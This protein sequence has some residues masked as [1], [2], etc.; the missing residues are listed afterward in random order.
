MNKHIFWIGVMVAGLAVGCGANESGPESVSPAAQADT[1]VSQAIG[2]PP[3]AAV[4]PNAGPFDARAALSAE[5]ARALVGE[6]DVQID[7][8]PDG[9]LRVAS[10][11]VTAE[12]D[13]RAGRW[14]V[15]RSDEAVRADP[16][17]PS[18][19]DAALEARSRDHVRALGIADTEIGR[20]IQT[21]VLAE[22]AAEGQAPGAPSVQAYKTFIDRAVAGIPVQGSRIVVTYDPA[23][24]FRRVAG[25]WP[26][27]AAQGHRLTTSLPRAEIASRVTAHLTARGLSGRAVRAHYVYV[28]E[29]QADGTIKLR[30]AAEA[31]VPADRS[32]GRDSAPQSV[33][34]ELDR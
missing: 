16:A 23:G 21:A 28:P 1:F 6:D 7:T 8:R 20:V 32:G 31:R 24:R 33:L 11:R 30:L 13:P 29:A 3:R 14:L 4:L 26:A 25:T 22:E 9:Q 5:R 19:T 27:L 12:L 10:A 18:L 17:A 15:L 34:V 2:E